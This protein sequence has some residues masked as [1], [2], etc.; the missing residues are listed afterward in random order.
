MTTEYLFNVTGG[1]DIDNRFTPIYAANGQDIVGF[2]LPDGRE[3]NI[4]ICLRTEYNGKEK[5][6]VS[7]K[8]MYEIGFSNLNYNSADFYEVNV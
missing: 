5:Y 8:D 2:T 3:V 1:F 7:E 6:I 4:E